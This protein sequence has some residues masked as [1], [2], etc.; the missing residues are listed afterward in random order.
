MT[1]VAKRGLFDRV[2]DRTIKVAGFISA[3]IA[4]IGATTGLFGWVQSQFTASISS[5][6]NDF[7]TEVKASNESQ[8]L[9]IMRLELMNLMQN[10]PD[11]IVEIEMLGRKYF[12]AGGNSYMSKLYSD[13]AKEHGMD[14]SFVVG[15]K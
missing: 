15:G 7:R 4:I 3:V 14:T 11:N 13:Y 2:S 8:D 1:K 12:Q 9:A 5:Q 10:D 6:I